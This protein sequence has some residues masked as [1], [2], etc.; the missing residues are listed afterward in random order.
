MMLILSSEIQITSSLTAPLCH[1]HAG[2]CSSRSYTARNR[3]HRITHCMHQE[4]SGAGSRGYGVPP[5][6]STGETRP[7]LPH[8]FGLKF[9]SKLVHCCNWL[10]T[11]AQCKIISVQRACRPKLF[12]NLCLSLV[13][14]VLHFFFRTTPL[15]RITYRSMAW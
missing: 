14:G 8:F 3:R 15:A 9:V 7:P 12:K 6:F 5:L 1:D 2:M 10:L 4:C 13:S 11:E